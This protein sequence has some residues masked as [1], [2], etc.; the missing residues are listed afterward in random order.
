MAQILVVAMNPESL[1]ALPQLW[2]GGYDMLFASGF[3]AAVRMLERGEPDLLISEVRLG[4]YN[5][6]HLVIRSHRTHPKMRSILLDRVHDPVTEID[7]IRE[8]AVYLVQP[9]PE[10]LVDYAARLLAESTPQRRWPRKILTE[11][12]AARVA[13]RPARVVE[14]SYG[15]MRLELNEAGR[16]P[17]RFQMTIPRFDMVV[18]ARPIW[19]RHTPA[20]SVSC[21][22]ELS[23]GNP[24][25]L[26]LW[27]H[28]VDSVQD[29]PPG[30][31]AH[32]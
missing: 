22:A 12:L 13:R 31:N 15:G 5:A 20:G 29:L 18:R 6:L 28:F 1:D 7:A 16:I 14:L 3:D 21:G 9:S 10:D 11:G 24:R 17:S 2:R 19:T 26:A 8:G 32:A 25:T 27:R 23:E 4:S 30:S